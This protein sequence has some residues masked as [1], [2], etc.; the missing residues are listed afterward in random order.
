MG[1]RFVAALALFLLALGAQ[2]R[3]TN[4]V[5]IVADDLGYGETGAQGNGQIP[6]PHIDSIARDGVRFTSGYVTAPVCAPSRAGMLSGRHQKRFGWNINVMP[7][8]PGGSDH[9][10][11]ASERLLP[12]VLRDAGYATGMVGKWHLGARADF[13]PLENGFGSFFGYL[14]EG[15]YYVPPPYEGVTTMLR[16]SPLPGGRTGM[17]T[18]PDGIIYHDRLRNEPKYDLHNPVLD[19][20]TPVAEFGYLTKAFTERAVAFIEANKARPFFL[21]C[22]HSAVHSP[23]QADNETMKKFAHIEDIHRRIF[24]A[25]LSDLDTS[26]GGVLAKL[27]EHELAGDTLVIFLS[28]NGGITPELTSSNAPLRGGKMNLYEGGVRVPFMMRWPGK[29]A[30]GRVYD[31]PVSSLDIYATAAQVSGDEAAVGRSDG[32]PLLPY[33]SGKPSAAPHPELAWDYRGHAAI[34][35]GDWKAIRPRKA[36]DWELYNLEEDL[37]EANDLAKHYPD[38]LKELVGRWEKQRVEWQADAREE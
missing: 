35:A 26:V 9:G 4:I 31:L 28:D 12:E 30:A 1:A 7:H 3:K 18:A 14:H 24:A 33:L 36:E 6:T 27:D 16:K 23:L 19:G 32:V 5:L 34:R 13:H 17:W 2:A 22:A 21:Y 25:M 15:H 37:S 10:I 8:V 38:R 11:P 29:I 20:R